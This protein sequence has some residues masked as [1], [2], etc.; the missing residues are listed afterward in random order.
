MPHAI[1]TRLHSI[2]SAA[3]L[4]ER[5]VI[6][7]HTD[8]WHF[9]KADGRPYLHN[10]GQSIWL[11][12]GRFS[13]PPR[14]MWEFTTGKPVPSTR[15][16]YRV[17]DSM[18]CINPA[19][20]RCQSRRHAVRQQVAR[21]GLT[22]GRAAA[23]RAASATRTKM[24]PELLQWALESTQNGSE[25]AHALGMSQGRINTIRQQARQRLATAAPS[26]FALGDAINTHSMRQRA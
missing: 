4:R 8:C 15:V 5:C 9:R 26:I 2:A 24:T 12:G 22:P 11:Y 20:L 14:A 21:N 7:R 16:V 10:Q 23:L 6:D 3:D 1:G 25:A 17:C 13:T 18:D 19:H